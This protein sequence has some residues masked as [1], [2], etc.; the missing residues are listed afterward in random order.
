MA[1]NS[2]IDNSMRIITN[3]LI[4]CVE[5]IKENYNHEVQSLNCTLPVITS[6]PSITFDEAT[7]I[8]GKKDSYDIDPTDEAKL[9]LYA[10]ERFGCEFIFIT[11]LPPLKQPFYAREREN[12]ILIYK[13]VTIAS[14][15][16]N[17]SDYN[18]LIKSLSEKG[19]NPEDYT[20]YTDTFLYGMPPHGGG[21]IEIERLVAGLLNLENI[22]EAV[23][24]PRD[25]HHLIP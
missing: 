16:E 22:R 25:L 14:G 24:F 9:T 3:V 11:N 18:E 2:G 15:S 20:A 12:F 13:G 1:Y 6:I 23:L 10:K 19:L 21:R 7:E 5:Y 17:I 4:N 8:L